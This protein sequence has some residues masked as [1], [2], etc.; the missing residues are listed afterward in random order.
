MKNIEFCEALN[1]L[2][3]GCHESSHLAF[4]NGHPICMMAFKSRLIMTVYEV[5]EN[6]LKTNR[7]GDTIFTN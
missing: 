4:L 5:K 3:Q 6:R 2:F 1:L 7:G